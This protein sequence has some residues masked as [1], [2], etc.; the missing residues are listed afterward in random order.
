SRAIVVTS[1][2]VG[3]PLLAELA[4][5]SAPVYEIVGYLAPFEAPAR[6]PGLRWLGDGQDLIGLVER[7]RIETIV[8][9]SSIDCWHQYLYDLISCRYEGLEVVDLAS[10]CERFLNR[11]PCDHISEL[12]LLWGL[13]GRSSFYVTRL[14]R[15]LDL[16]AASVLLV[17]TSPVMIL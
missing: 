1:G 13:M 3:A 9:S 2:D 6:E 14:K 17:L 16:A 4:R 5:A 10:A 15:L 7:E 11:I 8:V 12:W